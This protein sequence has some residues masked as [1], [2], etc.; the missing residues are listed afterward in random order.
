MHRIAKGKTAS[1][2]VVIPEGRRAEEIGEILE[3]AGVVSEGGFLE[4]LVKSQYSEPFLPQVA[5][6]SLEGFFFPAKYE[7]PR[8]ARPSE[9]VDTLLLGIPDERR[10]QQV[11]L[12]GQDLTLEEVVTLAAIVEREAQTASERPIIASVFLN[13]LRAGIALQAD[14]TVQ[15][16]VARRPGERAAVRHTGRKS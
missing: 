1:R 12:E 4:A 14:P 2:H 8:G 10:R 11:Q 3:Q 15:Y 7:F 5:S 16:A 9:V 6:D 13:R